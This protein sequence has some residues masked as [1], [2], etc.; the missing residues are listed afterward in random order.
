MTVNLLRSCFDYI[1]HL[2]P[3]H[4]DNTHNIIDAI[5]EFGLYLATI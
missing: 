5:T 2:I 3:F 1:Q 4:A